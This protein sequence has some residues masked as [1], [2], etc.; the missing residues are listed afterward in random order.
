[1]YA[2]NYFGPFLLTNLLLG[3]SSNFQLLC[4]YFPYRRKIHTSCCLS[5]LMKKS[6]PSRIVNLTSVIH[7]W[8][9]IEFDNLSSERKFNR[10]S[11]YYNTKLA[12]VL[13]TRELSKRLE[14]SGKIFQLCDHT[15][16]RVCSHRGRNGFSPHKNSSC[17]QKVIV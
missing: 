15:T 9:K 6:S 10:Y 5:E 12:T 1:M 13:F 11:I 3:E 4:V 8:G 17:S 7:S 2:T 14:G 16:S